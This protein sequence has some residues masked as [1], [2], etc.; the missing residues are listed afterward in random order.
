MAEVYKFK[1]QL[2]DFEKIMW[3]EIEI[4]STSSMAKLAYT[5]IAS[6]Y[7]KGTH[8]FCIFHDGKQFQFT[9]DEEMKNPKTIN[10]S[11]AKLEKR[12]LKIG[13]KFFMVYDFGADWIFDIELLSIEPMA[14][15]KGT[16]YPYITDGQGRGIIEDS[17]PPQLQEYIETINK[18]GKPI[19]F[20]PDENH[21]Y[22][23]EWDYRDLDLKWL[24]YGFKIDIDIMAENYKI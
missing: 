2:R 5:I 6:F 18:T 20:E 4:S 22:K 7:G 12:N 17:F 15:G 24:N 11:R 16:H 23:W 8:L 9:Y 13:D 10:P 19:T 1:V 21:H 3:R 14:R